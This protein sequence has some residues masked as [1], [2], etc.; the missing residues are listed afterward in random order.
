MF[1]LR[2]I[3]FIRKHCCYREQRTGRTVVANGRRRP[4]EMITE[5]EYLK[6]SIIRSGTESEI[7]NLYLYSHVRINQQ[8][9]TAP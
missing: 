3:S 6:H 1:I 4:G 2:I 8:Q 7:E 5:S 9:S